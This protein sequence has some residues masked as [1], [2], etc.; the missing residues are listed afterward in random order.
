MYISMHI[1]KTGGNTFKQCLDAVFPAK[2]CY[3]YGV[4]PKFVD[5]FRPTAMQR[6][7]RAARYLKSRAKSS[8]RLNKSHLCLHGHFR[9]DEWLARFPSATCITW[10]RDPVERVASQYYYW[11]RK[12]YYEHTVCAHVI[13]N[14]LTLQQFAALEPMRNLQTRYFNSLQ[15]SSFAF[16]GIT[17]QYQRSAAYFCAQFGIAPPLPHAKNANPMKTGND[18]YVLD[19][20]LRAYIEDLNSDDVALYEKCLEKAISAGIISG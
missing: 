20:E 13:K 4:S 11:L 18:G 6:L 8:G 5:T 3:R 7:L 12:P 16:V 1:P 10:V 14:R 9:A 19:G 17:E 2:V 15:P